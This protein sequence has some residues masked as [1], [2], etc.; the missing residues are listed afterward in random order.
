MSN[1]PTYEE[2]EQRVKELEKD[3]VKYRQVD[4]AEK[5]CEVKYGSI[6]DHAGDSI[7][8]VDTDTGSLI[9]FN[10]QASESLGYTREEFKDL[11]VSDIEANEGP[12]EVKQHIA[13]IVKTG[14]DYFESLHKTKSGEIKHVSIS[15]GI[16]NIQGKNYGIAISH[17]LSE[18]KQA[19]EQIKANLKEKERLLQELKNEVVERKQA[20]ET[21]KEKQQ[22]YRGIFNES[23]VAIYVFNEKKNFLDSNQAG[24]D[25]LGYSKEELLNI[26]ISDVDAD[27][28]VV[29]PAHEQLLS[30]EKIVNFE[31]QLR[32][33]DGSIVT[34]LNNSRPIEDF[35]GNVIGMQSTLINITERKQAEKETRESERLYR[36]L[37]DNVSDTIWTMDMEM[38]FTYFSPSVTRL[39]GYSVE[40]A[41]AQS[42]EESMTP[43]SFDTAMRIV[44]EELEL[45]D[46]G[47]K[48]PSSS[49]KMEV[50][51]SCKD[52]STIWTEIEASFIYDI[53]G[54]PK[55]IIGVTRDITDRKQAEVALRESEERFWN[56]FN[57]MSSGCG[58]WKTTNGI[59]FTLVDLNIAGEKMDNVKKVEIVDKNVAELFPDPER[60]FNVNKFFK[61]IWKTGKPER[62]PV[63]SLNISGKDVWRENYIYKLA[64]GELVV[65]FDDI[66]ERKQAEEALRE[67]EYKFRTLFNKA[68]DGI[69]I[70]DPE[71]ELFF[72]GNDTISQMLGYSNEEIKKLKG[73]A[74]HPEKDLPYVVEQFKKQLAGE[75]ILATEIP[76]Q[77]K[78]GS[79]FYVDISAFPI[80]LK[81]KQYLVG[82]FKDITDRKQ[83]EDQLKA[84]LKEKETLLQ[85]IH[86][87]VKNNLTVVSSLLKL[88][89]NSTEDER[90]KEALKASQGRIYAMSAVH[91]AL[92][93][94]KNLAEMDLKS[95]LSKI[96]GTLI[97]TYSVNPG[98]V[99]FNVEGDGIILNIEK[100]SPVGLIVNELISNSL[101]YAFPDEKKGEINVSMNKLDKEIELTVMDNGVGVPD[102]FDWK[103][104]NTLGLKLV[105]TLVENQLDGSIDLDNTNGTKFTIKFNIET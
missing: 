11:C 17:D 24:L 104:S 22:N 100:T 18:H 7:W 85:E 4:E 19:E 40:E 20:E 52:G 92:Y 86:H 28:V 97:Q 54:R 82:T 32:R 60:K 90:I 30:K 101:K 67:G 62:L 83:A 44:A 76:V 41:M 29:L 49:R 102:G 61:R 80:I 5:K 47:Q 13:Q 16:V 63:M 53:D 94:V 57:N 23:V 50:E 72:D 10:N 93:N 87:R 64:T 12:N 42:V 91:E 58:V 39:R 84:S 26:S 43:A 55:S 38:K 69:L 6:F 70:I 103:N 59:E 96:S 33:K 88:Q 71:T 98:Q 77:R 45:H 36:L 51:L 37:A 56:L 66:T 31:H 8:V 9:D 105:R 68:S 95:Y 1:K 81:K 2:L 15:G 74:I 48:D 73:E 14:S 65:I 25:L 89:G 3:A 99:R 35:Q 75:I 21:L 78:D 34:V 27:P 79:I 46:K